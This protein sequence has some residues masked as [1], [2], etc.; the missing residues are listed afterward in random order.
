M[1]SCNTKS[2][3]FLFI[4]LGLAMAACQTS[5]T[6]PSLTDSGKS[7]TIASQDAAYIGT[8]GRAVVLSYLGELVQDGG[9]T[10]EQIAL[11]LPF[12][13]T[14]DNDINATLR[15]RVSPSGNWRH[16]HPLMRIQTDL[17]NDPSPPKP[18]VDSLAGVIFDLQPNT[19]YDVEVSVNVPAKGG[20]QI[21]TKT[22]R[23]RALPPAAPK[24]SPIVVNPGDNLAAKIDQLRDRGG[25]LLL[26]NGT[27]DLER[28][29]RNGKASDVGISLVN[30]H[31]TV[32]NPIYIRG[33]SRDGTILTDPSNVVIQIQ[34]AS[35]VV[36]ENFTLL[37]SES[38]SGLASSSIG[39][40]FYE[41]SP[42]QTN[43]TFRNM[44]FKGV[45]QGI[46]ANHPIKGVLVYNNFMHGNNVWDKA[47]ITTSATWNDD[48]VRIPGEGN[49]AFNNTLYGFGDS[50][51][52]NEGDFSANV[53]FYRNKITMTGD[54][55][56]EGDFATR[57]I[58]IYDNYVGNSATF[59]SLD[60]LW[61]G[62]LYFFRNISLNTIRGPFKFNDRNVGYLVYNNT[63][64]RTQGQHN[65]AWIQYNNGAQIHW[66]YRNN[67]LIYRGSLSGGGL[68][69]F[70]PNTNHVL[71]MSNNAWYPDG[72]IVWKQF[73]G[74]G[75][76]T[77]FASLAKAKAG[78]QP[79]TPL[80]SGV[81]EV[82]KN[83]VI[84][85][86]NP[87]TVKI[88]TGKDFLTEIVKQYIPTLKQGSAA[89]QSGGEIPNITDGYTGAAP[90]RGAIIRGR[91]VPKFGAE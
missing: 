89:S 60:P 68:L 53:H 12:S 2:H 71:D 13:A 81:K 25:V 22:F 88:V 21:I 28:L 77:N 86:A 34:S 75:Y 91:A 49:C 59:L 74:N 73:A 38:D 7:R 24:I 16:G 1:A 3:R 54:D 42:T 72:L 43:I 5:S 51:A 37:G 44:R 47:S 39:V 33:E 45:D 14:P 11:Y 65:W 55:A 79:Q 18:A 61:G 15:Y 48:G 36:F 26:K 23:T 40:S 41:G 52:V 35:N 80:F 50:F 70:A 6:T 63:I 29:D 17:S 62:P 20:S 87:F 56:F 57:N 9:E 46:I 82:H 76:D 4:A 32:E 78:M 67:I 10:P 69:H 83:D 8:P 64:V 27:H 66:A 19:A 31:G 90:D 58:G 85:S 84:V 30:L